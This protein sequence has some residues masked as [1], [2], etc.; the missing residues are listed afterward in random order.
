MQCVAA[1]THSYTSHLAPL[2]GYSDSFLSYHTPILNELVNLTRLKIISLC[3]ILIIQ[4]KILFHNFKQFQWNCIN[5]W[6]WHAFFFSKKTMRTYKSI[7]AGEKKIAR[8][9]SCFVDRFF[10]NWASNFIL[11]CHE[12]MWEYVSAYFLLKLFAD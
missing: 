6:H 1:M 4:L 2:F 5:H 3:S 7:A 11:F 12:R 8:D 10:S 9:L